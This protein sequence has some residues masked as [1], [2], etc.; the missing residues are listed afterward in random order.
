M[1]EYIPD[2]S[3]AL[4]YLRL[5]I[6]LLPCVVLKWSVVNGVM[7]ALSTTTVQARSSAGKQLYA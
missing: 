4:P 6:H 3:R 5:L 1:Y 2:G 7:A